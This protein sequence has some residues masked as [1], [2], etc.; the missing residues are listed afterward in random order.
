[1]TMPAAKPRAWYPA[2][3]NR[4][5][6]VPLAIIF[7]GVVIAFATYSVRHHDIPTLTTENPS[8]VRAVDLSDH[9]L[10]NPAAPVTI[11][12][13]ADIDSEF[14]KDFQ[15]VMEQVLQDYGSNGNI[16]WVYRHI[17]TD[18]QSNSEMHA[19]AAECVAALSGTNNFFKFIDALQTAAPGQNEF[20]PAGYDAIVTA[21][22]LSSGT[23]DQ[24]MA[25]HTYRVRVDG[26]YANAQAI[27]AT[28][29]PFSVLLIRGQ[30]PAV[31]E[32][33]VPYPVLKQIIDTSISKALT[34]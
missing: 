11:I 21:L 29:T 24:C 7:A 16:A 12:E 20:D 5:W 26:D 22:G 15:K 34:K 19:E 1:M 25:A 10:G 28:G 30:K 32:G 13:Y 17:P 2:G 14:S 27:G 8:A 4:E 6:T 33:S 18:T 9:V 23:F 31:I 3:M